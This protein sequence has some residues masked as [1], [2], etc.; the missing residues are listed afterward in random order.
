M[1]MPSGPLSPPDDDLY[2]DA[3]ECPWCGW[4]MAGCECEEEGE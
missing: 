4:P 1:R 2:E 3:D